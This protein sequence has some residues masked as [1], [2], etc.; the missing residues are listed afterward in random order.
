MPAP[1][2]ELQPSDV[3]RYYDEWTE[4]YLEFFGESLQAH[5]PAREED[6]LHY[7]MTQAGIRDGQR[8]L[9]AGCGIC[10]PARHFARN[11]RI[12]IEALTI[13]PVQAELARER[14]RAARLDQRI[15]VTIG[16]FHQLVGIYGR[17]TFDLVYFLESLSHSSRP[18]E[19][20]RSVHEVLKPGGI[21]YVKDFFILVRDTPEEQERVL[22]VIERVDRTF[23]VKSP[24]PGDIRDAL[25][26]AGFLPL[27]VTN[28][29]FEDDRSVWRQFAGKH[30]FDLYGDQEPFECWEWL[31]MKSQKP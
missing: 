9:D 27:F 1:S 13:S 15:H 23:A 18:D 12:S 26:Q 17:E 4:K 5:R 6:L 16:D 10:G 8:I 22:N 21:V 30:Q 28:P 31:E 25:R 29:R 14:N 24:W 3:R 11:R 19:V 2:A 7:L 20:L